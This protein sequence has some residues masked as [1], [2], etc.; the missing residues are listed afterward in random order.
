MSQK[1]DFTTLGHATNMIANNST[2]LPAAQN[3]TLFSLDVTNIPTGTT[4]C[5][6]A[7]GTFYRTDSSSGTLSQLRI[8]ATYNGSGDAVT[9]S[10][11][12]VEGTWRRSSI[13]SGP[14][15]FTKASGVNTVDIVGYSPNADTLG[16]IVRAV[17]FI[18]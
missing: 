1:V 2:A 4:F 15:V 13:C 16:V 3:T 7:T 9:D 18:I 8:G 14:K 10:G 12:Y 5:V 6:L 11:S 17:A